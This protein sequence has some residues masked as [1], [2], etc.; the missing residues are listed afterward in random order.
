MNDWQTAP[1]VNGSSGPGTHHQGS[2]GH[3][4]HN[5]PDAGRGHAL[6]GKIQG[7]HWSEQV[8]SEYVEELDAGNA[9]KLPVSEK[10]GHVLDH[11]LRPANWR[12][13]IAPMM[14]SPPAMDTKEVI[15]PIRT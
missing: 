7:Q 15:S 13:V 2:D 11:S 14:T 6:Q 8:D 3:D 4:S 1:P 9:L 10:C 5:H 12:A